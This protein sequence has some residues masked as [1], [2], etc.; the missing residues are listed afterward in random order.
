MWIFHVLLWMHVVTGAIGLVALW[1]PMLGR[2]GGAVHKRWGKVFAYCLLAT[3]FFAIGMSLCTLAAP[4]ETHPK[5]TDIRMIRGLFGYMMLYLATF[6]M[7][8]AWY[9][10]ACVRHKQDH[11]RHRNIVTLGFQGATALTAIL[12]AVQGWLGDQPLMI[13]ISS[14]GIVAATLNTLYIVSR[15]PPHNEWLVQHM[16]ALVGAGVSIYTAFF[17]FG[18][19]NLLPAVAFNPVL[20]ATPT[21][22]GIGVIGYHQTRLRGQW[23]MRRPAR[24]GT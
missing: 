8:L 2:K 12:C 10:L 22:I 20:W 18:A 15:D 1:P 19:A 11:R 24:S 5:L 14:L 21:L 4:L 23:P 7:A 9:G 6:T 16:R 17:S 13:G 3:S